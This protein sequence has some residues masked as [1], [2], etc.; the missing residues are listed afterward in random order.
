VI[1]LNYKELQGLPGKMSEPGFGGILGLRRLRV[2]WK[3]LARSD[4]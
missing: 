2:I 3:E 1:Y 4:F